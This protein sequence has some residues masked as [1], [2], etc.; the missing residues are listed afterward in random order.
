MTLHDIALRYIYVALHPIPSHSIPFQVIDD[1][2]TAAW[3]SMAH[4]S[5]TPAAVHIRLRPVGCRALA[6]VMMHPP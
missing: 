4:A 6:K 3:L 5:Q 1:R 2:R